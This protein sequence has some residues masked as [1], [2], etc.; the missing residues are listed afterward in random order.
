MSEIKEWGGPIG[1]SPGEDTSTK[2][3]KEN[4]D[5]M[6]ANMSEHEFYDPASFYAELEKKRADYKA[7]HEFYS[8]RKKELAE[9]D[10]A[11]PSDRQEHPSFKEFREKHYKET[12][13]RIGEKLLSPSVPKESTYASRSLDMWVE[14]ARGNG[15]N[16]AYGAAEAGFESIQRALSAE[17]SSIA[18]QYGVL[19][20]VAEKI[21]QKLMES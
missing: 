15:W 7:E 2:E 9:L 11:L 12:V 21:R 20:E 6:Y 13:E 1:N 5:K 8:I 17:A 14:F 16:E 3:W 4:R 10:A 19:P 18:R